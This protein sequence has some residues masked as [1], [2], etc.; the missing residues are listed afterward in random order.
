MVSRSTIKI[1]T[2]RMLRFYA[3]KYNFTRPHANIESLTSTNLKSLTINSHQTWLTDVD[4]TQ[5]TTL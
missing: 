2:C 1:K 3:E 5:L 4:H